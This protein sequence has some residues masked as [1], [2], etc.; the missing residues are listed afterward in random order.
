MATA[1]IMVVVT[2]AV[3]MMMTVIVMMMTTTA[4]VMMMIDSGVP[5][6]GVEHN[7][8]YV[9]KSSLSSR[10]NMRKHIDADGRSPSANTNK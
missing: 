10:A 2:M 8:L 6:T 1:M 7:L 5:P 4:M 9:E 3:A